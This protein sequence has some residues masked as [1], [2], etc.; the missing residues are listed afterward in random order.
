[1][2]IKL[3]MSN[4]EPDE[5]DS[6]SDKSYTQNKKRCT[7]RFCLNKVVGRIC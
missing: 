7:H 6:G 1:M 3:I 4:N 5:P 2:N